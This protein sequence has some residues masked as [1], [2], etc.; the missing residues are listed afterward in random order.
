MVRSYRKYIQVRSSNQF[1]GVSQKLYQ[2]LIHPVEK[3]LLA[4]NVHTLLVAPDG[5]LRLVPFLHC[6]I[7]KRF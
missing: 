4:A 1:L 7:T 5:V 2:L 6:T 3:D